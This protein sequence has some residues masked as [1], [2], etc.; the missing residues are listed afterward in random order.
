MELA[1]ISGAVDDFQLAARLEETRVAGLDITVRRHGLRRLG[2]IAKIAGK[3]A[4]RLEL[5]LAIWRDADINARR[6]GAD[7][8]G[9]DCTITLYGYVHESFCLAVK[10]LQVKA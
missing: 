7:R 2:G 1:D 9:A 10:L 3:H 4:R 8:V 5:H 6:C